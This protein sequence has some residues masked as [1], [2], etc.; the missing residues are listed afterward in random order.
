MGFLRQLRTPDVA[1]NWCKSI[2]G[3]SR[4]LAFSYRICLDWC[5][6]EIVFSAVAP[7]SSSVGALS[8]AASFSLLAM[9][10]QG[11]NVPYHRS[12][13]VSYLSVSCAH[14]VQ[15]TSGV[16]PLNSRGPWITYC[17]EVCNK[18]RRRH[19]PPNCCESI[20]SVLFA[21]LWF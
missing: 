21:T 12:V 8:D 1:P 15:T 4:Y 3:G 11:S 10:R 18:R 20:Q 17:R 13:S 6:N 5:Q 2:P 7:C 19:L 9:H 16:P 14:N